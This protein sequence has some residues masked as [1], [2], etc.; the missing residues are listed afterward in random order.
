MS[1]K[2]IYKAKP[3]I[4]VILL[5]LFCQFS[6]AVPAANK[7]QY[8]QRLEQWK[9]LSPEQR[10]TILNN[11]KKYNKLPVPEKQAVKQN[12]QEWQKLP[13][14]EREKLKFEVRKFEKLPAVQ[15]QIYLEHKR[16]ELTAKPGKKIIRAKKHLPVKPVHKLPP[17]LE[18]PSKENFKSEKIVH[19]TYE[20]KAKGIQYKIKPVQ[21]ELR[22]VKKKNQSPR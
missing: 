13:M 1:K 12:F 18:K 20:H 11:Y 7:E 2:N 8:N 9:K 17:L 10:K 16:Q 3:I 5:L 15:K 19:K 6:W 22:L 14:P 4:L 21:N